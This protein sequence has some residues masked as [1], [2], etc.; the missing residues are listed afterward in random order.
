[1]TSYAGEQFCESRRVVGATLIVSACSLVQ[2]GLRRIDTDKWIFLLIVEA[3][4]N[5]KKKVGWN[6]LRLTVST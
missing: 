1:M 5:C 6:D 3:S 2:S 4:G